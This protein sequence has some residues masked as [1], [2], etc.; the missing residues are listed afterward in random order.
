[1]VEVSIENLR[2][3]AEEIAADAGERFGS[4]HLALAMDKI[5]FGP[6]YYDGS[7]DHPDYISGQAHPADPLS[8]KLTKLASR[9]KLYLKY[10]LYLAE[11][12]FTGNREIDA[13]I[14]RI[15]VWDAHKAELSAET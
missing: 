13:A 2:L 14:K 3:L 5:V 4:E 12:G 8:V 6:A 10:D 15:A 11:N 7:P 9:A 1:M